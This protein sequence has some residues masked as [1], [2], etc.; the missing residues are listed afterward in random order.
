MNSANESRGLLVATSD[1]GGHLQIRSQGV[2]SSP[3]EV[4]SGLV[5]R[6]PSSGSALLQKVKNIRVHSLMQLVSKARLHLTFDAWARA[7]RM[8]LKAQAHNRD[9]SMPLSDTVM[10]ILHC[11]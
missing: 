5:T 3:A 4:W 11:I 7:I 2:P 8:F 1:E 6:P 10:T 9:S